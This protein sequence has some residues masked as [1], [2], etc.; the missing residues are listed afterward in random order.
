M[1][2]ISIESEYIGY[3]EKERQRRNG[4]LKVFFLQVAIVIT[5]FQ[6]EKSQNKL[7]LMQS[8]LLKRF[9]KL[10]KI[11]L[12]GSKARTSH[13][14]NFP[15]SFCLKLYQSTILHLVQT[16]RIKTLKKSIKKIATKA[17]NNERIISSD[18]KPEVDASLNI[19]RRKV[20]ITYGITKSAYQ[21][22]IFDSLVLKLQGSGTETESLKTHYI[23]V[24][25]VFG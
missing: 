15:F 1:I 8:F 6:S 25:K 13:L 5:C 22:E 23:H 12:R 17:R 24:Y 9:T 14:S 20:M 19:T 11:N 16:F 21:F 18:L 10:V 7:D 4:H 2:V 3:K